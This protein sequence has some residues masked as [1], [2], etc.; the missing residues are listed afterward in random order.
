M[1]L[2]ITFL[3]GIQVALNN[4]DHSLHHNDN[5]WD[6]LLGSAR[7]IMVSLERASFFDGPNRREQQIHTIKVL[8]RLAY[9]DVDAGGVVDL[10]DWCLQR[11]LQLQQVYSQDVAISKGEFHS[12]Y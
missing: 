11:W 7:N 5:D 3:A 12:T 4:L 6:A 2:D 8:Q 1:P 9:H 10:A